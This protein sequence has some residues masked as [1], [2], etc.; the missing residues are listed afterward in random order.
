MYETT[1]NEG[2]ELEHGDVRVAD[3]GE[4]PGEARHAQP[5]AEAHAERRPHQRAFLLQRN[6]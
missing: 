1:H 5:V 2:H 6:P 4:H 3:I